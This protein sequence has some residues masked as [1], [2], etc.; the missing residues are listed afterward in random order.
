MRSGAAA[1]V[2]LLLSACGADSP[3]QVQGYVEVDLLRLAPSQGGRLQELLVDTGDTVSPG[4]LLYRLEATPEQ[5]GSEQARARTA[6]AEA[7]ARDLATGKRPEEVDVVRAQ[8]TQAQAALKLAQD[9]LRR[10]QEVFS[11]GYVSRD[12]L[13][14]QQTTVKLNTA[15]VAE[16]T[17]SLK[18]AELAARPETREAAKASV[19]AAAAQE[20]LSAWQLGEKALHAP[21]A[22]HVQ[23]VYFRP[24]EWVSAGQ[25][26]LDLYADSRVKLRF[27]VPEPR[28]AALKPGQQVQANCDGCQPFKATVSFISHQAEFTPPVIYSR[29]Q[30]EK[31]VYLVEARPEKPE[32]LRA[33]QPVDITLP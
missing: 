19:S 11:R 20:K 18:S 32:L 10:S 30:R 27:Y 16:L 21:L 29:G 3:R 24:G 25:P 12:Q 13:E 31:L 33:G 7:Q 15:R 26:V 14:Q 1:A 28:L 9:Q 23:Q 4:Q 8:L 17:A 6:Q 22:A 5:A 2:A